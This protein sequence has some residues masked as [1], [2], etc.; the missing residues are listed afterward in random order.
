M[1]MKKNV[2]MTN[3][4][5]YKQKIEKGEII[6]N[7]WV[8]LALK[9]VERYKRIYTFRQE[10]A[11]RY[12]DFIQNECSK[13]KGE[14]GK[15]KLAL[16]QRVWIEVAF[17]FYSTDYYTITD[18]DTMQESKALETRRLTNEVPL[19]ISRGSGKTTIA[20]AVGQAMQ[21]IDGE[22][23]ADIQL[24]AYDKTQAGFLRDAAVN[25]RS[26][27]SSVIRKLWDADLLHSSREGIVF[28]PTNS[29]MS[30]V[31]SNYEALDG[32]NCQL[33]IF[34]E[35]HTYST[36]FIKVATD[37]SRK[38]RKNW[39]AWYPT[40]NGTKRGATF[41]TYL[42]KWQKWLLEEE[43]LGPYEKSSNDHI[44][45]WLYMLDDKSEVKDT[46]MWQ[47]AI[48]LLG[49]TTSVETILQEIEDAKNDPIAQN[50]IMAKTFNLP[51]Q[52]H[53]AY[54]STE[55]IRAAKD[56]FD[57]EMLQGTD[58]R[59][60]RVII[61]IDLSD[62]N[63]ICSVSFMTVSPDGETLSYI[64]RKYLPRSRVETLTHDQMAQY[65][66]WA[67]TGDLN[68]HSLDYN[69][70]KMIFKDILDTVREHKMMPV[71]IAY[72]PWNG[73]ELVRLLTE[74]FGEITH[75]IR[76][77]MRTLSVPLKAYKAKM[78]AGKVKF[79]DP[80]SE[81]CHGNVIVVQDNNANIKPD[82][83][84]SKNKI[85]VMAS[86]LDA[87]VYFFNH[88]DELMPYFSKD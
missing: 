50:E 74:R 8:K 64:N 67:S 41:D 69:D 20:A 33:S 76:Q 5:E 16:P 37:G 19:L 84:A 54:F 17:G 21:I 66:S 11:D 85:D 10:E 2:K 31:A 40:T 81:W 32:S 23:G 3:F 27:R 60:A 30:V 42:E 73:D 87:F 83:K 63:D 68:L 34:D 15:L 62:V 4:D 78:I 48:P 26:V 58:Y 14:S 56:G 44:T 46:K 43:K 12:I 49:I 72:D 39:M 9:R 80:V 59:N 29:K 7:K 57:P 13:T 65:T 71:A 79:K 51:Q 52:S 28:R 55:E 82:K 45:P 53:M 18:L 22:L 25:M 47:K 88:K 70:Q 61:G 24:L 1:H 35:V 6:A 77:G 36:D 75:P 86:Q 38:K